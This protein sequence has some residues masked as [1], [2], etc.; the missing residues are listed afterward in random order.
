MFGLERKFGLFIKRSNSNIH[1]DKT[2]S[3][4]LEE[5]GKTNV[6]RFRLVY[7]KTIVRK[8]N[9]VKKHITSEHE[10][11]ETRGILFLIPHHCTYGKKTILQSLWSKKVFSEVGSSMIDIG[12]DKLI[13][14][15][16]VNIKTLGGITWLIK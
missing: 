1:N 16:L 3:W 8:K 14:T 7:L 10:H 6:Q 11:I 2:L 4:S 9:Y 5:L 12:V 15:N 13:T